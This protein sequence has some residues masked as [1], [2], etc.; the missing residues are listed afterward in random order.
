MIEAE[1]TLFRLDGTAQDPIQPAI[2]GKKSRAWHP[3]IPLHSGASATETLHGI[4]SDMDVE[5]GH[6]W[7][8]QCII[9]VVCC[10]CGVFS[11][12]GGVVCHVCALWVSCVQCCSV[13]CVV[14][15]SGGVVCLLGAV[16]CGVAFL[17]DVCGAF[18][19]VVWCVC[20]VVL[21]LLCGIWCM[22]WVPFFGIFG[23]GVQVMA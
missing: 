6:Q 20:C 5:T 12:C 13:C 10:V 7:Y 21:F 4:Q 1:R 3:Y 23:S 15:V 18:L 9:C 2:L 17:C 19:C 22:I 16:W 11:L 8:V 14:S